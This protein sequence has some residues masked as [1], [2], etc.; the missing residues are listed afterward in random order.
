MPVKSLGHRYLALVGPHGYLFQ[1][2]HFINEEFEAQSERLPQGHTAAGHT[3]P[4]TLK[5]VLHPPSCSDLIS[6]IKQLLSNF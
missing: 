5:L 6:L 4:L 1:T 2:S 3:G